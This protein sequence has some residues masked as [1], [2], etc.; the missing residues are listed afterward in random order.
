MIDA[1]ILGPLLERRN[2]ALETLV[3]ATIRKERPDRS[4]MRLF[5]AAH[6]FATVETS[7]WRTSARYH[8]TG[9]LITQSYA[10]RMQLRVG[11]EL[12]FVFDIVNNN[13]TVFF[14]LPFVVDAGVDIFVRQSSATTADD[15]FVTFIGTVAD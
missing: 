7:H 6:G 5:A 4:L 2:A 15:Q 1:T 9:L 8:V 14:P 10:G 13:D 12:F 3:Q 11:A